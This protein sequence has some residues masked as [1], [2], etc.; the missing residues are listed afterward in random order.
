MFREELGRWL[1]GTIQPIELA[2]LLLIA[3]L[4]S[5]FIVSLIHAI[6]VKEG[7]RLSLVRVLA[8]IWLLLNIV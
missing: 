6:K 7:R 1:L 4:V 5:A 8:S 3:W 2:R